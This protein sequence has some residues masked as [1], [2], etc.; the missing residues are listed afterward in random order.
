MPQEELAHC[1]VR[2][3]V[4]S[5]RPSDSRSVLLRRVLATPA[6]LDRHNY[7]LRLPSCIHIEISIGCAVF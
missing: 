2:R 1:P 5:Q 4:V 7:P 6:Q 3:T